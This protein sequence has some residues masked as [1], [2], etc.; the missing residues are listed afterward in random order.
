MS[1][2]KVNDETNDV[3]GGSDEWSSC[4]GRINPKFVQSQWNVCSR[5]TR[6][7]DDAK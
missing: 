1:N 5:N 7:Y 2:T 4:E 6:K 3:I